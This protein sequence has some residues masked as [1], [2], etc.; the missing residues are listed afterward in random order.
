MTAGELGYAMAVVAGRLDSVMGNDACSGLRDRVPR[1]P[2]PEHAPGPYLYTAPWWILIAT[3]HAGSRFTRRRGGGGGQQAWGRLSRAPRRPVTRRSTDC[4]TMH[5]EPE[6][7]PAR[8]VTGHGSPARC[9]VAS[10]CASPFRSP[11][12][13]VF[14]AASWPLLSVRA[15]PCPS[16][17]CEAMAGPWCECA[18]GAAAR[19]C[20]AAEPCLAVSGSCREP[21]AGV[22]T[23]EASTRGEQASASATRPWGAAGSRPRLL[24]ALLFPPCS[25]WPPTPS[26]SPGTLQAVSL[27]QRPGP[28]PGKAP[29]PCPARLCS[30]G[31][32]L[33]WWRDGRPQGPRQPHLAIADWLPL[34]QAPLG[35]S[36]V[37]ASP[38]ANL[39]PCS[40]DSTPRSVAT[41][42]NLCRHWPSAP[43]T[44]RPP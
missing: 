9:N 28:R 32:R 41:D 5:A 3:Q 34:G 44:C 22:G 20:D 2:S 10:P 12:C 43:S 19:L 18:E 35:D 31:S 17:A 15:L 6:S 29:A 23:D 37:F 7:N 8:P 42:L 39:G 14:A 38:S 4:P 40:S 36:L 33:S 27:E 25:S 26:L 16:S 24:P 30:S 11:A 21:P 13:V 1:D